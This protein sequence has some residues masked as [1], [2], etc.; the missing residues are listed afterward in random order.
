MQFKFEKVRLGNEVVRKCQVLKFRVLNIFVLD[1][2][3]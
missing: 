1:N 2:K 3:I